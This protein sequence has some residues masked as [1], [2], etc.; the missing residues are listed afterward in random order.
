MRTLKR[1]SSSI[2]SASKTDIE[3]AISNTESCATN[4]ENVASE[5]GDTEGENE[6]DS[7]EEGTLLYMISV[8]V[9]V[10]F[11]WPFANRPL[12]QL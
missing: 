2:E 9:V 5:S 4:A 10:H 11:V 6:S 3:S 12:H 7:D 8:N 1:I